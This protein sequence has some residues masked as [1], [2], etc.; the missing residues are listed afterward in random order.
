MCIRD[1]TPSAVTYSSV[2]SRDSVRIFLL[3]AALNDI[4]LLSADVQNAFLT[5]PVLEKVWLTAG[6]EFGPEQGKNMIVVRALYGLKSASASFRSFMARKLDDMGFKSSR[7]DFD[8]WMRPAV[9]PDG[10]EYYKYVMLYV[11][12][13]MVASCDA[14][15]VMKDLGQ[16]IKFKGDK[17]EPPTSY[18]G[19]QLSCKKL[20]NGKLV[21]CVSSDK[22]V[23]AAVRNVEEAIKNKRWKIPTKVKTP[24]DTIFIP[25]LDGTLE[26]C[27][28]ERTFYQELVGIY[29]GLQN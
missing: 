8:I 11:D 25:E 9:K 29:N 16:G 26:L 28:D 17:I 14:N 24:M 12:D 20:L 5:A 18:L 3:I 23:N 19:A 4:D 13:V 7:G 1:R 27:D 21:W 6:P 2:A 15:G 22:Y 10:E